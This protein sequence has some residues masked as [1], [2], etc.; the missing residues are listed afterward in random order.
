MD[1]TNYWRKT[2]HVEA[3]RLT[4]DNIRKIVEEI[5]GANLVDMSSLVLDAPSGES[6]IEMNVDKREYAYI[7]DW[8]SHVENS[9]AVHSHED[10]MQKFWTEAEELTEDT[11]LAKVYQLVVSAMQKQGKATYHGD[12]LDGMDLV[13]MQTTKKILGM[14]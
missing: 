12:G 10:F 13:A 1:T 14:I 11:N 3:V 2:Y 4:P 7:G 6:C 9:F 8:I 5:D